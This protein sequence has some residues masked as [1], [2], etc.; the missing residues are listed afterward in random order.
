VYYEQKDPPQ[1]E[2]SGCLDVI[3][4]MRAVFGLLLWPLV[5]IAVVV[6]DLVIIVLLFSIHP[7][8]ALIPVALTAAG[9]W[10]YSRWEQRHFRPPDA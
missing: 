9:I 4:I 6:A 3:V 1:G 7:A 2:R 5:A 10:A 8:L